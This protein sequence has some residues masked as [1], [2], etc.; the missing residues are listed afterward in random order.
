MD[1]TAAR[2]AISKTPLQLVLNNPNAN[3]V[4]KVSPQAPAA[5]TNVRNGSTPSPDHTTEQLETE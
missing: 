2:D 1:V 3:A 5:R 4:G